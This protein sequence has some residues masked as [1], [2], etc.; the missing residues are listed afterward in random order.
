MIRFIYFKN[1]ILALLLI[2][3]SY[4]A[5]NAQYY[6]KDVFK[7]LRTNK[8]IQQG[9]KNQT[10]TITIN[11]FNGQGKPISG[12]KITKTFYP[13][14]HK[15]KTISQAPYSGSN[16]STSFYDKKER[17]TLVK[18]SSARAKSSTQIFYHSEKQIDSIIFI[19]YS[20]QPDSLQHQFMPLSPDTLREKH[21]FYYD[22]KG[23]IKKMIRYKNNRPYKTIYFKT[24]SLG[25]IFK[26]YQKSKE[27]PIYY[28]RHKAGRL[29][30]VFHFS[31]GLKK[32][33]PNYLFNYSPQGQ[34][35][36][37]TVV[38]PNKHNF[39]EWHYTYN[40]KGEIKQLKGVNDNGD[41]QAILKYK[42]TKQP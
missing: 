7:T 36:K 42:Y 20:D 24:D 10:K 19:T 33:I 14:A 30:D 22:A 38:K 1:I 3:L 11:S 21:V 2:A 9:L 4:T 13:G 29:T 25:Q 8:A 15:I 39:L 6:Y 5:A 34:L 18:D 23:N 41:T 26:E 35:I 31:Y 40:Q 37:K 12:F 32:M 16:Y 17:V 28:Y 27:S